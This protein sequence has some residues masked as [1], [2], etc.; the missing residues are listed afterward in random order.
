MNKTNEITIR[1]T[2]ILL[3]ER[4][5]DMMDAECRYES[6]VENYEQYRITGEIRWYSGDDLMS[7]VAY[8]NGVPTYSVEI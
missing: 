4:Y 7:F 2:G 1:A 3:T 6:L 5:D 8:K